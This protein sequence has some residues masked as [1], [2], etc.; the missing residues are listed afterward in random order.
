MTDAAVPATATKRAGA[1][2]PPA[3]ADSGAV[4]VEATELAKSFGGF[5]AVVDVS[6]QLRTGEVTGLVG[7]NGAGKTTLLNLLYGRTPLTAGRLTFDGREISRLAAHERVRLGLGMVFQHTTV[8]PTLGVRENLVLGAM[9]KRRGRDPS[10]PADIDEILGLIGLTDQQYRPAGELSHGE[11]QWLE[12]AMVLLTKPSLLL[13]DEP[14]SGMTK[15]EA[16]RMAELCRRLI[17]ERTVR[18]V[19]VVEHNIDFIR[20]VSNHVLVMHRGEIIAAGTIDE[21]QHD[22]DVR[23]A[24]LGPLT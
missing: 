12:I 7:S 6:F 2:V 5:Y 15:A 20:H 23:D 14:T 22:P 11:Q 21:V 18:A 9:R 16:Q 17:D 19:V 24:F 10:T 4:I 1:A 8:F 13:L 3:P